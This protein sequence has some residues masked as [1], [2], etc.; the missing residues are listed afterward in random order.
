[1]QTAF[2]CK[3]FRVQHH[4]CAMKVGTDSLLLG[5]WCPVPTDG[6]C[7]DIGTGS[8]L[9][10]LMLAQ[11]T[12]ESS[13]R[14]DAVE[15]DRAAALQAQSNVASSPWPTRIRVLERDILTY[16]DSADHASA[17]IAGGYCLIISNPPYFE[18]SLPS[19]DAQRQQA[20]HTDSLAFADLLA[21]AA[22]LAAATAQ[23]AL[24]LPVDAAKRIQQMAP[25]HGWYVLDWQAVHM[26]PVK[27]CSRVLLLLSRD[28][29]CTATTL[30]PL[31]V[32]GDDGDYSAQFRALL[33]DFYLRF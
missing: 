18:Q 2:Q 24:V 17:A 22:R 26:T 16:P 4:D 13:I 7:L 21:V 30:P 11:R 19:P 27:P 32:R 9:L 5:A 8:G 31:Y 15:L 10:A 23:F 14:I 3:Q 25:Q 33:K 1:M 28:A 20:R 6:L 12:A 29:T